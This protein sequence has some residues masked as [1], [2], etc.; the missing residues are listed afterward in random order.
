MSSSTRSR[1]SRTRSTGPSCDDP[2]FLL[3]EGG[4]HPRRLAN[5]ELDDLRAIQSG[6]KGMLTQIEAAGEGKDRHPESPRG[7]QPRVR[8]LHRSRQ[9]AARAWSPIPISASRRSPTASATS[10]RSSRSWRAPSS[11]PRTASSRWNTS[12][13]PSCGRPWRP[14]PPACKQTAQAIAQLDV[15]CS[16]AAVA[17]HNNYCRPEV[18][19]RRYRF[20]HATAAIRWSSRCSRARCSSRTTRELGADDCRIGH[21]HRPEHGR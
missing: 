14:N 6:G 3:R 15:L 5:K 1:I 10:P 12:C 20:H 4:H 17:V 19:L 16:F 13:S 11:R 2:P 18:D 7:L 21:H 9:G 8:L